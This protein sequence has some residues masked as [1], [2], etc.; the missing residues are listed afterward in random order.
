MK[1]TV[2]MLYLTTPHDRSVNLCGV[3][4]DKL[5]LLYSTVEVSLVHMTWSAINEYLPSLSGS[6]YSRVSHALSLNITVWGV[7]RYSIGQSPSYIIHA[8]QYH[9]EL[10]SA[11]HQLLCCTIQLFSLSLSLHIFRVSC[12][13]TSHC[14]LST[15]KRWLPMPYLHWALI[16]PY[17]SIECGHHLCRQ[18]RDRLQYW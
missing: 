6:E 9:H 3:G 4:G 8:V 11:V 2:L 16:E 10:I 17:L 12:S 14:S 13:Q 7:V 5:T 1:V 18:C 15:W